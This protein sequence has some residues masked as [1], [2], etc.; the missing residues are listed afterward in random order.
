MAKYDITNTKSFK[1]DI[2]RVIA[3]EKDLTILEDII[4]KIASGQKLDIK[5]RDHF[6]TGKYKKLKGCRECHITPDWLLVYL[7]SKKDSKMYLIRTGSHAEL[8]NETF[9]DIVELNKLLQQYID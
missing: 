5:Y 8:F 6:L 3:Q 9:N 7:L 1:K 2:D 4:D